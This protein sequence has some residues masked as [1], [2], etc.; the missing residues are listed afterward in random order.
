M[1]T[2]LNPTILSMVK[3][4]LGTGLTPREVANEMDGAVH[5][6]KILAVKKELEAEREKT[7]VLEMVKNPETIPQSME[8]EKLLMN[9]ALDKVQDGVSG[10]Q[11]LD[12]KFHKLM[13]KSLDRASKFLDDEELKPAQW[14]AINNSL[15]S[16]YSAIFNSKGVNVNVNN[17]TQFSDTKLS[18]FKDS[19]R[20]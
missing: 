10:L 6:T 15:S 7:V 18:L 12:Q 5:Y 9:H 14:V 4:K 11:L 16:A 20:G 17:G 8:D 13:G 3:A 1:G 2:E 19:M